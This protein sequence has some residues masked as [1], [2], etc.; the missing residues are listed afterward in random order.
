MPGIARKDE[1]T[2]GGLAIQGSENVF[3]NGISAVRIGDSIQGHGISPHS[4]P[5]MSEGSDNV[6]VNSIGV[7]REGDAASCGHTITGSSNVSA[8]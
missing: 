2:A 7:C 5:V 3:V 8:N 6:F 4:S 1:D